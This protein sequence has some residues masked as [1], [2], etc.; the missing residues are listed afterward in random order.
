MT[1]NILFSSPS[2]SIILMPLTNINN[3]AKK[4]KGEK[5]RKRKRKKKEREKEREKERVS[6]MHSQGCMVSS[7]RKSGNMVE[8]RVI[9]WLNGM[10]CAPL[11]LS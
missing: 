10:V 6:I 8:W 2:V 7:K 1:Q 11:P 9:Q 5:D 4:I 3:K